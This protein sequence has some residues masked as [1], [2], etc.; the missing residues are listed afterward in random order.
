MQLFLDMQPSTH[1][2]DVLV[3]INGCVRPTLAVI[4]VP[5]V[6]IHATMITASVLADRLKNTD[7]KST[8]LDHACRNRFLGV[9]PVRIL[10]L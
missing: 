3:N 5:R 4:N 8:P 10:Y 6:D 2:H 1:S 9:R 7:R